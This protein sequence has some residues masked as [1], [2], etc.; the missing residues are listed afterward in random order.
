MDFKVHLLIKCLQNI[1]MLT[2]KKKKK[3]INFVSTWWI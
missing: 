3:T 1:I 2:E